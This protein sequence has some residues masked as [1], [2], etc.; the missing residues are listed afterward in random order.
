MTDALAIPAAGSL[1]A[2]NTDRLA[3]AIDASLAPAT[4]TAYRA[5]AE[6]CGAYLAERRLPLADEAI[7]DYLAHRADQGDAPATLKQAYSAIGAVATAQGFPDPR[8]PV[9]RRALQGLVRAGRHRGRGPAAGIRR[10]SLEAAAALAAGAGSPF[11]LRDA[12]ILRLGSDC[13]LR[14]SEI[15]AVQVADLAADDDGS[16]RLRIGASKTDQDGRGVTLYVCAETMR[17]VRAWQAASGIDSGPL[18]RR[19]S[20]AGNVIGDRPLTAASIRCIV[21]QRGEAAGI[22]GRLSGHSLRVGSAQSLVRRGADL[23]ALM[24]AGRWRD[25]ATAAGYAAGELA[26]R[27][28]V[29]RFF[30]GAD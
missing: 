8:G 28:A 23:P 20:R 2:V 30:G 12:A 19:L 21:R 5:H 3:A 27:G 1:Q 6:R 16:G 29:A 9:T 24:Q 15:A 26:G 4:R 14:V 13:L 18:F 17:T 7:A 22:A 25:A 11:G 10:A